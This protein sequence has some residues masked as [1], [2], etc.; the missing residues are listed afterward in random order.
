MQIQCFS[1]S[2]G[3]QDREDIKQDFGTCLLG[4]RWNI[5]RRVPK[6]DADTKAKYVVAVL[7]K[8]QQQLCEI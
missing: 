1:A 8:L 6:K 7:D 2:K 4:Q 3:F 5:A